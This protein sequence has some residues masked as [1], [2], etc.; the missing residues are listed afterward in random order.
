MD[1][2]TL[3]LVG[4]LLHAAA[5]LVTA[6]TAVLSPAGPLAG[7]LA[8]VVVTVAVRLALVPVALLRT[9]AERDRRRIAP[10][11]AALR[12]RCGSDRARFSRELQA[13][14]TAEGVSPLAGCLPIL[15]QAP[16]VSLLYTLFTHATIGGATNTLLQATLAGIPLGKSAVAVFT[17]PLWA[18][19]WIVVVLLVVLAGIVE[20][21]RRADDRW[22]A[23]AATAEGTAGAAVVRRVVPH[24]AVVFAAFAP[25]AAALYVVTSAAW[26]LGER[27]VL[28]RLIG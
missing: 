16:V 28:R 23:P 20:V 8:V 3:P 18:H 13:L 19:V 15:L 1:I 14:M 26:A 24:V 7:A 21:T 27:V 5:D 11:V 25:L 2:T 9:R 22:N 17:A 4:A 6:L 10:L 12:E